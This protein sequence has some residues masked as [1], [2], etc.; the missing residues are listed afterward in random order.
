MIVTIKSKKPLNKLNAE[1]WDNIFVDSVE[2]VEDIKNVNT[3]R[4]NDVTCV[5]TKNTEKENSIEEIMFCIDSETKLAKKDLYE[6]E[7]NLECGEELYDEENHHLDAEV[8]VD[9]DFE[10]EC[11]Y[12]YLSGTF[13]M[14]EKKKV[15]AIVHHAK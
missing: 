11:K 14:K 8:Y 12:Y 4:L 1:V 9:E 10:V 5:P 13:L 6:V 7:L 3:I 15:Y 2:N